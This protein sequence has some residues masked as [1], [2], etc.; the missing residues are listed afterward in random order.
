MKNEY[1]ENI[2][3]AAFLTDNHFSST[4]LSTSSTEMF[5]S[6]QN[7]T[8]LQVLKMYV[9]TY[10][11]LPTGTTL[12]SSLKSF[13]LQRGMSDQ[14]TQLC[15]EH[16]DKLY[17]TSYDYKYLEDNYKKI[18]TYNSLVSNILSSA[19][20]LQE[21]GTNLSNEDYDKILSNI[22]NSINIK[23]NS[24][25]GILLSDVAD[26][27][28]QYIEENSRY[29][30]DG[31]IRTGIPS[32][33]SSF[34]AGGFIP[35]ELHVLSCPPG[36]GKTSTLISISV[37]TILEG[38]DVIF[39]A[40]GDNSEEDILLRAVASVTRTPAIRVMTGA[41]EYLDRWKTI[42]EMYNMGKFVTVS[43]PIGSATVSDLRA[44]ISATSVKYE[45]KPKLVVIDYIDNLFTRSDIGSYYELGR[46]Y[47]ETKQLAEELNLVVLTASQSK[48][49]NWNS[50]EKVGM[51]ELAGSSAKSHIADGIY[52]IY[53]SYSKGNKETFL[54][55]AKN[56]RGTSGL[57]IP[58]S[59]NLDTQTVYELKSPE[60]QFKQSQGSGGINPLSESQDIEEF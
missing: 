36:M 21:K 41:K 19:Q 8:I 22:T 31:L 50:G 51:G 1:L 46:L 45:L 11:K 26:H 9:A 35:Q 28:A 58:I 20:I 54:Y 60:K 3:L 5:S 4:Y 47:T 48:V 18:A 13:C 16:L 24:K 27:I 30:K 37:T 44:F 59:I 42:S 6:S 43:Y 40:L 25:T 33:D 38:K 39:I 10:N 12:Y 49:S 23:S 2:V 7:K 56:R 34:L 29:D 55:I 53:D 32:L 52:T 15:I 17:N 14:V 57:E